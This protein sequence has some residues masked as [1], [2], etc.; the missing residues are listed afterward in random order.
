LLGRESDVIIGSRVRVSA[1]YQCIIN[2]DKLFNHG[3]VI[4]RLVTLHTEPSDQLWSLI[5]H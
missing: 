2:M 5:K 1:G 4:V 3:I